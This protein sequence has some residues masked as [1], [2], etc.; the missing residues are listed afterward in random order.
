MKID[1]H[2]HTK[3]S[4][5]GRDE[6]ELLVEKM[7]ENG[8]DILGI[9]DHNYGIGTRKR[10][11]FQHINTLKEK[12]ADKIKI[13][14]GI[15]ICTLPLYPLDE[16]EDLSYFEYAIVEHLDLPDSFINGDIV[17]F[18]KRLKTRT[19]IAHTDLFTYVKNKGIDAYEFFKTLSENN[20]FWE[21][22]VSYDS[23]HGYNEH[24]YV[25]EFVKNKEQQEIIRATNMKISVGFDG[26]RYED[27]RADRVENMYNFLKENNID[28]FIP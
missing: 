6:P 16:K 24:Q 26:H 28:I 5:C 8:V 20:I 9:T 10:E 7:I 4:N 22:N 21:M 27:Y 14:C 23:I 3:Y 2:S 17:G 13:H 19:G 25:K 15:E 12:Y 11:Y 18:S 1:L